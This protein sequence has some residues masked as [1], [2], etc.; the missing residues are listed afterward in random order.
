MGCKTHATFPVLFR[1]LEVDN[2]QT[3][4]AQCFSNMYDVVLVRG[5]RQ[6]LLGQDCQSS[7]E[8]FNDNEGRKTL[9]GFDTI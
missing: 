4:I 6:R 3:P 9:A 7:D 1:L 2:S 5:L 8:S